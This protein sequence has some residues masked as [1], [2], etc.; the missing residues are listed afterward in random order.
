MNTRV[1]L[2][3]LSVV[4]AKKQPSVHG[5]VHYKGIFLCVY[6]IQL[7]SVYLF[8]FKGKHLPHEMLTP[9]SIKIHLVAGEMT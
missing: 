6:F 7:V 5:T 3:T 8:S 9:E 2:L 4:F 1:T